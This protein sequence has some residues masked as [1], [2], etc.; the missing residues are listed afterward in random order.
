[1]ARRL[2]KAGGVH[3]KALIVEFGG[4]IT[5]AVGS[6]AGLEGVFGLWRPANPRHSKALYAQVYFCPLLY[7]TG[8]VYLIG[9]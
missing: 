3:G 1:V 6:D 9:S 4:A 8:I 7:D 2:T 5:S